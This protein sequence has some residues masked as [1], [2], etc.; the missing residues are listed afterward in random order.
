VSAL[1]PT[2]WI[3][4]DG[5]LV[6]W[7]D[8]TTHVL[9]HALHYG[10]GVFEGIRVY[11][12]SDGPA[13]FRLTD[14]IERLLASAKAYWIPLDWSADELVAAAASV[15]E[16]N[17]LR[18]CYLRPIAFLG[19]GS[20]G[21]DPAG[22]EPRLA[23]AAWEWGAYLGEEGVRDGI[24]VVVSSWRRIGHESLI[25]NAKGTGQYINSVMA[26]GEAVRRGYDEALLLNHDGFVTEGSGENLFLVRGGAVITPPTSSGA[27]AGITRDTVMAL[28]REDGIDVRED[29][30]G[31][32][33]IYYADELFFTGTA[34]E[35]TPIREIDDRPVGS[36]E[37]GPVTRRAQELF[38]SV[39][40]GEDERHH[41]WLDRI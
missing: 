2:E 14:H 4:L 36:G 3:W 40:S 37:P 32:A 17:G 27:L 18:A 19:A 39:V 8:A 6:S 22:A 29:R 1:T 26:K 28:L 24:R 16:A 34:A 11:D 21:L 13:G 15:V 7:P 41:D 9:S 20:L 12:T 25:P 10:T 31:R 23:I 33:D 30:V 35:V 38:L 5:E